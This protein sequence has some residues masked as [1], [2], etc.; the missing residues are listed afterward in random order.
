[1]RGRHTI[2][3]AN[4]ESYDSVNN[5]STKYVS[6]VNLGLG[7]ISFITTYFMIQVCLKNVV[8]DSK[9]DV[10]AYVSTYIT[11]Y[12]TLYV[13]AYVSTYVITYV[14]QAPQS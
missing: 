12:V 3:T 9:N 13:T 14:S 1:V 5:S 6:L 11:T 2:V 10:T 8:S 4:L 7:S